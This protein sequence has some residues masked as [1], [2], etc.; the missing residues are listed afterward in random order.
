MRPYSEIE[1]NLPRMPRYYKTAHNYSAGNL[2]VTLS[3]ITPIFKAINTQ[4]EH[5][6]IGIQNQMAVA[7]KRE[8]VLREEI[9][10]LKRQK[11]IDQDSLR[12]LKTSLEEMNLEEKSICPKKRFT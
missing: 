9:T 1:F 10:F 3:I 7:S 4:I 8:E 12:I 11:A 6:K 5:L 2:T